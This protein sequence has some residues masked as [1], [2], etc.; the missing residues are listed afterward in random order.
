MVTLDKIRKPIGADLD[1]FDE[2]VVRNF[3]AEGE[4]LSDMLRYALSA[5]G[6]GIRPTVVLLAAGLNAP[7]R[8]ERMGQRAYLAALLVEMI[9]VASLIHDDVIDE[10]DMRRGKPSVNARWQ[11]H[12]AVLLGD[13]I[14]ARN[15]SIGLSSGQFDLVTHV[16]ETMGAL[17]EGEMLQSE[18]ADRGGMTRAACLE[19]IRKKTAALI[20]TSA[21]AG[22]LAVGAP[23]EKVALM[24]RFG[25]ALGMAFQIQDDILDYTPSA[26]TGKPANN[27]LRERK[28]TLPLLAVLERAGEA[29]RTELLDRLS[30]C[31]EDVAEV[32]YCGARSRTRGA[33][34]PRGRSCSSIWRRPPGCSPGTNPRTTGPR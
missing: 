25:E 13:Y 12:R 26:Q 4:L 30:R 6:K 1:A 7:V 16:V 3:T 11:S 10:S 18:R 31:R 33:S 19:I 5:R 29:R 21:S 22:A 17:C 9:H 27:D 14:L 8:R 32:E 20:A 28:V 23:R 15:M 34:P 2:F 24:H